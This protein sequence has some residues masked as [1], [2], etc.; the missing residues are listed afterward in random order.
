MIIA[1]IPTQNHAIY[2]NHNKNINRILHKK[3]NGNIPSSINNNN[4]NLNIKDNHLKLCVIST[5][6]KYEITKWIPVRI[7]MIIVTKLRKNG[8]QIVKKKYVESNRYI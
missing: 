6:M 4:Y 2:N 5:T 1:I 7:K 3:D 8:G